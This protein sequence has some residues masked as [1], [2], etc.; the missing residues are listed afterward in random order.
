[1]KKLI[2]PALLASVALTASLAQA[3]TMKGKIVSAQNNSIQVQ[4]EGSSNPTTLKTNSNTNYYI[5]KHLRKDKTRKDKPMPQED[6]FV[7]IIYTVDPQ[8][9]ELIIDE[10]VMIVD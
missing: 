3:E 9:D 7:E 8:T 10:L 2:L 5:K 6:E 4:G 1:M